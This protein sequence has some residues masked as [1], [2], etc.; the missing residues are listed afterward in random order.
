MCY[1]PIEG[2]PM[3]ARNSEALDVFLKVAG[4]SRVSWSA[5]GLAGRGITADAES[6]VW[7][8]SQGKSS[9]RGEKLSDLLLEQSHMVEEL[10]EAWRSFEMETLSNADFEVRLDRVVRGLEEWVSRVA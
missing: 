4:D 3:A 5:V 7:V 1:A 10:V 2:T 9:L 6:V 8:L